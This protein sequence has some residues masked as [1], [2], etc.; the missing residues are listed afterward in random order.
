LKTLVL[1]VDRDNDIG[2]KAK[3][4][5]PIIGY[6]ENLR[7]ARELGLVDPEDTDLNALYEA[8][9][10]AKL[11]NTEV[12]TLT[13]DTNVGLV[14]DEKISKQ[15]DM[16]MERFKPESVILI[17]DGAEDE[18]VIPII[19]SRV[20]INAI[21][22]VIVRQS[23]ELEKAYFKITNFLKEVEKDSSLAHLVFVIPG[24]ILLLIAI[25][26]ALNMLMPTMLLLLAGIGLYL[27]VKGLG[28]EE[29][30][31]GR[32][33]EFMKSLSI[34]RISIVAYILAVAIFIIGISLNYQEYLAANPQTWDKIITTILKLPF[35]DVVLLSF[36]TL[37]LGRIIDEYS[38]EKYLAIRFYI[39]LLAL[40]VLV[41]LTAQ[42]AVYYV[43]EQSTIIEL[44][45]A[46]LLSI[47]FFFVIVKGTA[48]V[49][50]EELNV[51]RRL[52]KQYEGKKVV[53]KEGTELGKV[54]KVLLD[55]TKLL[56]IKVGRKRIEKEDILSLQAE[57]VVVQEKPLPVHKH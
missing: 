5:G 15:I 2:E 22:T 42:S 13:G 30:F 9:K 14:S 33:N 27:I 53:N 11:L 10:T 44:V 38:M 54:T 47:I 37:I 31:F 6:E 18:Q 55:D 29:E 45:T 56:G 8:V 24:L 46:I 36:V 49:F 17:T 25:G 20:K 1:C 34:E 40:I 4:E 19:Q 16:V 12:V 23:R 3:I 39:I 28:I 32:I 41:T 26:G 50:I 7:A 35:I 48:L 43:E 52:R 21:R 51:Q 57:S